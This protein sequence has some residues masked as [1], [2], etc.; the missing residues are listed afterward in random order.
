MLNIKSLIQEAHKT[1]IEKGWWDEPQ[2]FENQ[3][4][5]MHA[6]LSEAWEDYRN[7]RGLNEIYYECKRDRVCSI[8][9]LGCEKCQHA[10]P[11]GIPVELADVCIRIFDTLGSLNLTDDDC[12]Y[13]LEKGNLNSLAGL[14]CL[15][16]LN[17]SKALRWYDN[18]SGTGDHLIS[19]IMEIQAFCRN[20]EIDLGKAIEIK[21]VYNKTRPYRHGGKRA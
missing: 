7:N 2:P 5:N 10:K 11:C 14:I 19:V 13:R 17:L 1:A 8:D 18:G 4:T 20:N 21:M 15:C 9:M 6:E 3:I 16:H 12:A